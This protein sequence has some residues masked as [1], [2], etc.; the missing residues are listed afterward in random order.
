M[1]V[2]TAA[3]GFLFTLSPFL[4]RAKDLPRA[5]AADRAR[6]E[7]VVTNQNLAV[8]TESR[9]VTLP[10]GES[11]LLWEAV[12]PSARTETWT[13]TNAREAGISWRGLAV[14]LSGESASTREWL[15]SLVGKNVKIAR[16]DGSTAEGEVLS[17][18][19]AT[20]ELVLFREGADLVFGEPDARLS[21]SAGAERGRR[22]A[23]LYLKLASERAG[24]REI[25]SRYLVGNLTWDA[26]YALTLAP[27]EK[28]GR[29]E[30]WFTVD[31]RT[32]A[33][34][35]PSRL[36]LLAGVLRV[37]STAP[38]YP[39]RGVYQE[40]QVM[41]ASIASSVA[42][43]EARTYEV[44]SPGRLASG[45]TTYP[46]AE[47]A[48]VAV[49]K[50][51]LARSTYWMGQND[52]SQRLPV[53][54]HYKVGT[55]ALEKA[56]P[57]GTVR[58]YTDSGSVFSG[59]DRIQ[60]TPERTD[61]EIETSEAFD[62]TARR[63]Q[64]AYQQISRFESESSYEVTLASRKKEPATVIVRENFPGDWSILESSI[65]SKKVNASTADFA[66][67]VPAGGEAKLTYRVRVRTG[68]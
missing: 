36:R 2:R 32:A 4:L 10:A 45:R 68:G 13:I 30:G 24:P 34:F 65:P 42:A 52:E 46:L 1:L 12:P 16:P 18:H 14:P 15:E 41:D 33:D 29:L 31:N 60:H 40:M 28:S 19:G 43:S 3:A 63:R 56:L 38:P 64:A 6:Q 26:N 49:E 58:V 48:N 5:K 61:V 9:R 17:V 62:L 51:Y 39:T 50:R 27:D 55:K 57:A 59:E 11:E 67:S 54:V 53:A 44:S 7:L 25:A 66:V 37:A 21:L 20:A 35:S 22:P 23:G 8:V 47:N